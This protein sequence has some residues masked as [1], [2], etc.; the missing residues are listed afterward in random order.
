MP[1]TLRESEKLFQFDVCRVRTP[2][3]HNQLDTEQSLYSH[4]HH[5][6]NAAINLERD[7]Q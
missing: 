1:K 5:M 2:T 6:E 7:E 4:S 3:E